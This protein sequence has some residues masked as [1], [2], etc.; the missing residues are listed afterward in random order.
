[1]KNTTYLN[2]PLTET[3]NQENQ[4]LKSSKKKHLNTSK[5]LR[6]ET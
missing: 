4:S 3:E 5:Y 2:V 1:M 6:E